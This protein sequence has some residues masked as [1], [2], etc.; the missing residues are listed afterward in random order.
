MIS[1]T[2]WSMFL[3][4][5][6]KF[7]MGKRHIYLHRI[8]VPGGSGHISSY[9]PCGYECFRD[10]YTLFTIC[11]DWQKHHTWYVCNHHLSGKSHQTYWYS[12]DNTHFHTG[13]YPFIWTRCTRGPR[14]RPRGQP[15]VT[16]SLV[17]VYYWVFSV[18]WFCGN[19]RDISIPDF[20]R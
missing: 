17:L 3:P 2:W 9:T 6:K 5:R 4:D 15:H 12:I 13:G 11:M 20:Y 1:A 16:F 8:G 14:I 18:H 7:V 10:D 19:F